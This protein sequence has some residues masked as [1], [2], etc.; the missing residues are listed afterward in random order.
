MSWWSKLGEK[1]VRTDIWVVLITTFATVS[2]GLHVYCVLN[3]CTE[4][5]SYNHKFLIACLGAMALDL[6][7]KRFRK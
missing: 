6:G 1:L 2:F 3:G 5:V 4:A 7:I